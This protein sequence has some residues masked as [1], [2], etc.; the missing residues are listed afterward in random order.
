MD[1]KIEISLEDATRF[2][3]DVMASQSLL[4]S[5]ALSV[6]RAIVGAEAEGQSGHGFSRLPAYIAQLGT[7]KVNPDARPIVTHPKPA[8]ILVDA[9]GGFAFPALDLA[10]E[11]A[12]PVAR[13]EGVAVVSVHNSHHCGSLGYQVARFAD[14][15]QLAIMVANAP[16]AMAPWGGR[17]PLFG[18]NPIAFAAP[19]QGR[20][21]IVIDLSLS[22]VARGKVMLAAREG[23]AIPDNWAF[24]PRGNPTTDPNQALAGTMAPI[25]DA[26]GTALALM[27]EILAGAVTGSNFSFEASSFFDAQGPRPHVGQMIM[28]IDP[29][30]GS[31]HTTT[32]IRTLAEI[33]LEDEGVR[34]PGDRRRDAIDRAT[35]EG[36]TIGAPLYQ[37]LS[38]LMSK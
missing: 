34:L 2:V 15:G 1:Q 14:K 22:R 25:G 17:K 9:D 16:K 10:Y 4:Q 38:Q 20:A 37:E 27:V 36:V 23:R 12:V 3:A 21:P 33:M 29:A 7:G 6:A 19:A 13:S 11:E 8:A 24:D 18:T 32:R 35:R 26:K 30:I 5:A 31:E 28:V